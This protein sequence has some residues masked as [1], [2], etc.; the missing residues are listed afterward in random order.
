MLQSPAPGSAV[1]LA[2]IEGGLTAIAIAVSFAAPRLAAGWFARIE[3]PLRRLA[4]RQGLAVVVVGVCTFLLRL[5][6]LPL[7]PA[8]LPFVPDDFSFL[9]ASDTFAHGRL[10]NP[11]PAMWVHFESIHISMQPT[12]GSMYFPAQ[13]LLMAAGKVLVGNP[14]ASVLVLSA[15]MCA[16]LCWMLQGWLPPGWALLGG[17]IAMLRLGLFSYWVNTYSGGGL[18]A[19]LGGALVLGSLPRLTRTGC[20]RYGV[21]MGI[22]MAL[23]VL[24]RPYEG[25]LLCLPTVWMLGRWATKGKHRPTPAMLLRHAAL[26]LLLVIAA[27]GW[28]GYYDYRAFGKATTLPYTVNR[29]AYAT[30]PY[31][32]WQDARPAPVYRHEVLRSFYADNELAAYAKIH[33]WSGFLPQTFIKAVRGV[34]FFAGIVLAVP[35]I[36]LRRVLLDRRI[37]FL[38]ICVL[39]L[40]AGMVIEIFMI[41]HYLAPFTGAFYAIG[42]QAMRHLRVWRPG[43]NPAGLTMVRLLVSICFIL[44]GLRLASGPLHLKVNEW[45]AS[46]WTG[47]WYGPEHFGTERAQI[48]QTLEQ[49]PGAQLVLVRYAPKHNALD[50]WVYNSADIG[51]SK[52]IWAREMD[53]ASN[54]ELMRYYKDR[55]VW[56]VEPDRQAPAAEP[57]P[58]TAQIPLPAK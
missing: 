37:R 40:I 52:V 55:K 29:T 39:V 12:Y 35:L 42:L 36:M 27:I 22:G 58:V 21:W 9:L 10:A 16:A 23:L 38:V 19:A 45:P 33:S 28:L 5:A 57:Y 17:M 34:L 13:G 6:M 49:A 18:I 32:V 48:E 7:F 43:S 31:Y 24:T 53:A 44:A 50:E 56:L 1:S 46:L 11:T 54:L 14:W 30:A 47:M 26:P 51:A 2:L 4:R 3:R 15:L 20:S 25:L 8:P 41:P